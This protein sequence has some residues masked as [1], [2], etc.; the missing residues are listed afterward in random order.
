VS[1]PAFVAKRFLVGVA[2]DMLNADHIVRIYISGDKLF[3]SMTVGGDRELATQE[4]ATGPVQTPETLLRM[5][6]L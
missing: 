3:A 1:Q 4:P 2:G 5:V 6:S